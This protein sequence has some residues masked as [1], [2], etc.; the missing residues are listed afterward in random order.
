MCFPPIPCVLSGTL[1]F[2]RNKYLVLRMGQKEV[3]CEDVLESM[4]SEGAARA[5]HGPGF[6][7][8]C[9]AGDQ[10]ASV[11]GSMV[12]EGRPVLHCC[13]ECILLCCR[14]SDVGTLGSMVRAGQCCTAVLHASCCAVEQAVGVLESLASRA[15][16]CMPAPALQIVFSEGWWVG[17]PEENPEERRLP[18][19]DWLAQPQ[20]HEK[21]DFSSR[22]E[23]RL[24]CQSSSL[25]EQCTVHCAFPAAAAPEA[26]LQRMGWRWFAAWA[27]AC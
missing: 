9:C 3:L 27:G 23:A 21:Y 14:T 4:V 10:A 8:S 2:P 1:L 17:S 16:E 5:P 6:H 26:R 24:C 20:L 19:P 15:A 12:R 22:G 18:E 7:A 25:V 13:L 11:L